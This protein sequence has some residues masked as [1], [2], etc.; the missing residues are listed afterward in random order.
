MRIMARNSRSTITNSIWTVTSNTI[1]LTVT[2]PGL[3]S[4]GTSSLS[5][6][7]VNVGKNGTQ[8]TTVTNWGGSNA[9]I[10]GVTVTGAGFIV[11][12]IS[13]GLILNPGASVTMNVIFAPGTP[14]AV[15]GSVVITSNASNTPLSVFFSGTGVAV[16]HSAALS[17]TASTSVVTGY[18]IYR[19]AISGGPYTKLNSSPNA[20][21]TYTDT[22]VVSGQ[23]YYY[24]C[25]CSRFQ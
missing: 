16:P 18:N 21:I 4:S 5:F 12:G 19:G 2:A 14:G 8:S 17:W 24:V 20:G 1:T 23:T 15:N 3:L 25:D 13:T 9:T 22:S 10:S 6:G 7:N 11:N